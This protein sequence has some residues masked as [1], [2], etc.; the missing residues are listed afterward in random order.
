MILVTTIMHIILFRA[1]QI[2][3]QEYYTL[4]RYLKTKL[5]TTV[6][7]LLF[8]SYGKS[9]REI[10]P[11]SVIRICQDI[12]D[13]NVEGMQQGLVILLRRITNP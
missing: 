13:N 10:E 7:Y 1:G 8:C 4:L 3:R 11:S 2:L 5:N 9:S 6:S 12:I